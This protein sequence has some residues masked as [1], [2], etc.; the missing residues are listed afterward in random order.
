MRVCLN[1]FP[2]Q[3]DVNTVRT[4]AVPFLFK[5][6]RRTDQSQK[7]VSPNRNMVLPLELIDSFI[8]KRIYVVTKVRTPFRKSKT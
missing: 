1:C 7:V 3:D 2:N 5:S 8:G 4:A 6:T